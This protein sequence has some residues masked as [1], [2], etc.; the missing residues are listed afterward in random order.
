MVSY[1]LLLASRDGYTV[2]EL[3]AL[4]HSFLLGQRCGLEINFC[5][6]LLE[7]NIL[8]YGFS[9]FFISLHKFEMLHQLLKVKTSL[10][11]FDKKRITS[12]FSNLLILQQFGTFLKFIR[13][14]A[15]SPRCVHLNIFQRN[16]SLVLVLILDFVNEL[17]LFAT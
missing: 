16:I 5:I 14:L 2:Y 9:I 4:V 3:D 1:V 6:S 11:S 12:R 10:P 7:L 15:E 8:K 13:R 17:L